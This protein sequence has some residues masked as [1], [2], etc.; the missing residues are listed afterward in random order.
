[1]QPGALAS[2]AATLRRTAVTVAVI[3][4]VVIAVAAS[5][6]VWLAGVLIAVGLGL[7]LVNSWLTQLAGARLTLDGDPTRGLIVSSSLKRLAVVTIVALAIVWFARPT[8]WVVLIG[9]AGYHLIALGS[10]LR[11]ALREA[12][13][14]LVVSPPGSR[15]PEQEGQPQDGGTAAGQQADADRLAAGA[16]R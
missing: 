12:R 2:V 4:A 3:A 13:T 6:G 7:G 16:P 10:L 1:V 15:S 9:L 14:P 8:G 5:Q 11:T